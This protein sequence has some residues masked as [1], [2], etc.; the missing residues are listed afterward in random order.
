M[1]NQ[2]DKA[3]VHP[4]NKAYYK[5]CLEYTEMQYNSK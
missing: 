1:C 5:H 3:H 2:F 4:Y